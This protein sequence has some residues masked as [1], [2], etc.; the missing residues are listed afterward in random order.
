MSTQHG[1]SILISGAGIAGPTLAYWLLRRGFEPVLLE[2]APRFREG[3]YV[4]DFWG[5]GYDVAERMGLIPRLREAGYVNDR[6]SFVGRNGGLRSSFGGAALR[7]ALGDRFLTIQRG[8]LA[9]AIYGTIEHRVETLFRDSVKT[10]EQTSDR[11]DV[12]LEHGGWRSFDLVVGADGLHLAVRAALFQNSASFERNLGYY[13]AVFVTRGYSKRDE[14]VYLSFAAPGRQISRFALREDQTGFLFVFVRTDALP[15]PA[16]DIASQKRVILKNFGHEP[17][18]EWP[19]IKR[20]LETC[21]DLYFDTVT[22]IELPFWS[23]GRAAL[24]GDAAY[25]PS[26]LAGEGAAFAMAWAYILAGELQNAQGD[27]A[28]AFASYERRF[29]PFLERKQRSARAFASSFAPNSSL[30]LVVRDVV[31]RL[32]AI[33]PVADLLMRRFVVDRFELPGYLPCPAGN[34]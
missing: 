16:H 12:C 8:D 19:E 30:G 18:V 15:D 25:S 5:I 28:S 9:H 6:I 3:G 17:W 4:I 2:R 13:V 33:P 31:L 14:H 22:Q 7:R 32:G 27:H 24:V 1:K 34:F 29:R 11:A 23:V 20:H 26:L 10:I 21:E